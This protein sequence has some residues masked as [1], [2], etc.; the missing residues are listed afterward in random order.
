MLYSL[1]SLYQ[2]I[3]EDELGEGVEDCCAEACSDDNNKMGIE[4]AA[5]NERTVA[6]WNMLLRGNREHFPLPNL[7]IQS[8]KKPLSDVLEYSKEEI[9]LPWIE[10][11]IENLADLTVE[12]A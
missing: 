2:R 3:G 6:G 7:K 10:Y 9:K 5:T 4:A 11:C 8:Q 1:L 12:L